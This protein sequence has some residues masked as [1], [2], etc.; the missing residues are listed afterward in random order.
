MCRVVIKG[1]T[2]EWPET[3]A[4]AQ[5]VE[6][7]RSCMLRDEKARPTFREIIE[8]L[9][10]ILICMQFPSTACPIPGIS[11]ETLQEIGVLTGYAAAGFA[12]CVFQT[13]SCPAPC[14]QGL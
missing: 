11:K 10:Q 5:F 1:E 6:L 9:N 7:G 2:P 8:Q 14:T 3:G 13:Q 12:W 4:P